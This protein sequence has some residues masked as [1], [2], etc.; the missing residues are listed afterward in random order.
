MTFPFPVTNV[1]TGTQRK[2]WNITC[3]TFIAKAALAWPATRV[4][5]TDRPCSPAASHYPSLPSNQI[6]VRGAGGKGGESVMLRK[7]K[8]GLDSVKPSR[9]GEA[10]S[11]R[12]IKA[13]SLRPPHVVCERERKDYISLFLDSQ[14]TH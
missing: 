12:T 14:S 11:V 6:P 8:A 1:E 7:L 4:Q 10:S 13:H 3:G 9:P 2:K 5:K